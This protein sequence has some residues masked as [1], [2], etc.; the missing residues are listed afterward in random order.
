MLT[1]D[2][3]SDILNGLGEDES[4]ELDGLGRSNGLQGVTFQPGSPAAKMV[5]KY[6]HMRRSMGYWKGEALKLRQRVAALEAALLE[7][8]R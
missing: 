4:G 3:A 5:R 7:R 2:E 1:R 8:A 6:Q